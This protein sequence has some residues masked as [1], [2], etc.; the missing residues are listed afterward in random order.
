MKFDAIIIGGSYAGLSA[1]LQLGRARRNILVVDAG[2]RRNRFASH[3]H[4]F[5]GQDGKTPGEIIAEAR[6]QIETYPTIQWASG[7]VTDADG[8]F[9]YFRVEIDGERRETA[10]RLILSMGVTDELP[11]IP[12]LKERWGQTIFHCP[13]CHGYELDKGR[14]GVIAASSL[15]MHHALMLPDWGETTLF[16]NGV[17]M[18]DMDQR[19]HLASRGTALDETRIAE[20]AGAADI[21]LADGR[22]IVMDGLFTQPIMRISARWIAKLGCALEDGPMGASIATDAMKQTTAPGI[23]ACGDIARAASS[24]ALSVGDGAMA[25][26]S[27]H[28]S[29]MF[30]NV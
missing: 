2:E 7:R 15:A 26:A 11:E 5:L 22:R 28:R 9:D 24:V 10:S 19:A 17:F 27:T 14:I 3:S 23:F 30:P 18:P 13:Y 1:A 8:S 16:T 6:R 29:L 12:G 25:G 21:L 20:I 4:G